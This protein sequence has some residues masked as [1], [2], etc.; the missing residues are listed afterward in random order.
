MSAVPE[1]DK[2]PAAPSRSRRD[3]WLWI[4]GFTL[5]VAV[6]ATF[7][8]QL[9]RWKVAQAMDALDRGDSNRAAELLQQAVRLDPT[10]RAPDLIKAQQLADRKEYA[11]ALALLDQVRKQGGRT[12]LSLQLELMIKAGRAQEVAALFT[13]DIDKLRQAESETW[14][15]FLRE[16][17]RRQLATVLN[18]QAY[19]RAVGNFDIDAANQ[20]IEEALGY[21][22]ASSPLKVDQQGRT[23]MLDTRGY[24]RWRKGDYKGALADLDEAVKR[25][26]AELK[27]K[28]TPEKGLGRDA[29]TEADYRHDLKQAKK[30]VAVIVYHR[31]LAHQSLGNAEQAE[32]DLARVRELGFE[33]DDTLF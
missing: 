7:L 3:A 11:E 8:P 25:A 21:L 27:E 30:P 17:Y 4:G 16:A 2:P 13:P 1:S 28:L 18:T 23:I 12:P 20:Q 5:L 24:I 9:S 26:E 31:A 6:P 10:N 19:F 32:K 33:P 29:L 14:F 15:G 22:P